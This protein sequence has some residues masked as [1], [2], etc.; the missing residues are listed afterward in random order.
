MVR[1]TE[2]FFLQMLGDRELSAHAKPIADALDR[3]DQEGDGNASAAG[4]FHVVHWVLC[5]RQHDVYEKIEMVHKLLRLRGRVCGTP[6][7]LTGWR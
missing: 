5:H 1:G 7:E 2:M 6:R 3:L 4:L